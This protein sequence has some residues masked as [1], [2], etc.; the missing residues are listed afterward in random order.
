MNNP[1]PELIASLE[2]KEFLTIEESKILGH[3]LLDRL[4][5]VEAVC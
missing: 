5:T 1:S 4:I 3:A 2:Q